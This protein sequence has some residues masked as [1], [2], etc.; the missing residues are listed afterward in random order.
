MKK[1]ELACEFDSVIGGVCAGIADYFGWDVSLT[2]LVYTL[3]T[4][5]VGGFPGMLIY[6]ILW[7]V[8]PRK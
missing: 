7:W 4:L 5:C 3:L 1:F 6:L 2:R 8:A